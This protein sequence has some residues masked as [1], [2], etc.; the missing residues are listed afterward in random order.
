M[1][2][3]FCFR[4]CKTKAL[5]GANR[6]INHLKGHGVK[7]ALASNSPRAGIESKISCHPGKFTVC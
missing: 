7:M 5:P 2:Y 3:D 6:L 1:E 4:W